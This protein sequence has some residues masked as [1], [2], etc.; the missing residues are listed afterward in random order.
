M[1]KFSLFALLGA[2][3]VLVGCWT[4]TETQDQNE[5]L[6]TETTQTTNNFAAE[7]C[8]NY[9]DILDCTLRTQVPEDQQAEIAATVEQTKEARKALDPATQEATC[10]AAWDNEILPQADLYNS[11][12]C[13]V[14]TT[15]VELS[16]TTTEETTPA[17]ETTEEVTEEVTEVLEATAE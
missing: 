9:F 1:K 11:F 3:L 12:G 14:P 17:E 16:D 2:S 10:Q 13:P 5:N 7:V 15:E 8:N 6:D 4:Q